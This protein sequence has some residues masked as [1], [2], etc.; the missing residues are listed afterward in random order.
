MNGTTP[1][2][3]LVVLTACKNAQ[4]AIRGLLMRRH[5]PGLRAIGEPGFLVHPERDPGVLRSGHD[6]LRSSAKQFHHALVVMDREGSGEMKLGR[7]EMEQEIEKRLEANGWGNRA[8][9]VVIQPELESWVWS[10]SPHVPEILGW[11]ARRPPLATWLRENSWIA[12]PSSKPA[13]PK[14]ALE[15]VLMTTGTSRSSSIYESLAKNVSLSRCVDPAFK[16]LKETLQ[17]WFPGQ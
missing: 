6:L 5:S 13:R 8:A 3:D 10:D 7:E 12:P 4:F 2:R 16:K 1:V 14:E 15:N 11:A 9:A 17:R